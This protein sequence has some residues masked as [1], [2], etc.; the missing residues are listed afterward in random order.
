MWWMNVADMDYDG[1]GLAGWL[2]LGS[3]TLGF[4]FQVAGVLLASI[5][6]GSVL[7]RHGLWMVGLGALFYLCLDYAVLRLARRQRPSSANETSND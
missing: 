6:G 3:Q 4:G 7:P 1:G 5:N 2:F